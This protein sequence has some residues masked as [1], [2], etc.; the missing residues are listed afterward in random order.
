[1]P[2]TNRLLRAPPQHNTPVRAFAV[3]SCHQNTE[4]LYLYFKFFLSV[5]VPTIKLLFVFL[6]NVIGSSAFH[7]YDGYTV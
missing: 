4:K 6:Y 1:M 3:T 5:A 2:L 7:N